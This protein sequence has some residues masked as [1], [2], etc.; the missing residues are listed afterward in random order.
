MLANEANEAKG[1]F[2]SAAQT[3]TSFVGTTER[4]RVT[5]DDTGLD[6][7]RFSRESRAG[8]SGG[9]TTDGIV[10]EFGATAKRSGTATSP[11]S[12]QPAVEPLQRGRATANRIG[13]SHEPKRVDG[14]GSGARGDD[15]QALRG[16]PHTGTA[17]ATPGGPR[18]SRTAGELAGR[19]RTGR[20]F[21]GLH[22]RA[23]SHDRRA[24]PAGAPHPGGDAHSGHGAVGRRSHIIAVRCRQAFGDGTSTRRQQRWWCP[25]RR[26]HQLESRRRQRWSD[27]KLGTR[28]HRHGL[29]D[30]V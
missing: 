11:F 14:P 20:R 12:K 9:S 24:R 1:I 7:A 18:R 16:A 21:G 2:L 4:Q 25:P 29:C 10:S 13:D 8:F 3:V 30:P 23:A 27:A 28:R 19:G 22:R 26:E 6:A 17:G 5:D 15:A